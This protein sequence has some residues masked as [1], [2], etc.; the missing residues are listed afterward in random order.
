MT[1]SNRPTLD[2]S[3]RAE[4]AKLVEYFYRS[5][6]HDEVLGP[7]F[8]RNVA[9]WDAHLGTMRAFWA[10]AIYRTGE[11]SGRPLDAHRGIP[12]LRPEHFP[13]WLV[14]WHHAVD[15]VVSSDTREPFKQLAAR[16]A[17]TMSDRIRSG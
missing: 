12:E 9:D 11:Y 2:A 5:A 8:E 1:G 3:C 14:L 15:A 17:T 13:R 6:R 16:M 4:I 10:S 7:I